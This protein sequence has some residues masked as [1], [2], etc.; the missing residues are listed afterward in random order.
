MGRPIQH[1]Q[2]TTFAELWAYPKTP[3][4]YDE[5]FDGYGLPSPW[6]ESFTPSSSDI[7]PYAGFTSGDPRRSVNSFR[8]GC[9]AIQ[10]ASGDGTH[11]VSR[12]VTLPTNCFI[13]ARGVYG[14]RYGG[15]NNDAQFSLRLHANDGGSL[16][17]D[18]LV[19]FY[20]QESDTSLQLQL[21][22]RQSASSLVLFTAANQGVTGQGQLYEY[23]G[24][25]KIGST[26]HFWAF[27]SNGQMFFCYT[28][29]LSFT[30]GWVSLGFS[31]AFDDPP[32][33]S[34]MLVDFVRF[35]ESSTFLPGYGD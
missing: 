34:I 9:Y 17:V 27:T 15:A 11:Y 31:N 35:K 25:Q 23:L 6:V 21:T 10:P 29:T 33:N 13:W 7:D 19:A 22:R 3:H 14:Y 24:I 18:N 8:K 2:I 12:L 1:K 30:P 28:T 4:E 20:F 5:E 32:G 26:Y 16:D